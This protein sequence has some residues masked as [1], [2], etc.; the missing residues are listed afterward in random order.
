MRC[1]LRSKIHSAT[2]TDANVDYVGSISIDVELM[3]KAGLAEFEQVHV[4]NISSGE[5]IETYVI[6]GKSGEITLNGAA[7]HKFKK[8]DKAIIASFE[9]TDSPSKPK[10][11]L[12]DERNRFKR[13]L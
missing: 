9:W 2:V 13:F 3:K 6:K 1:F 12:V 8:G 7:A 5:R 11:V 4:W 10:L